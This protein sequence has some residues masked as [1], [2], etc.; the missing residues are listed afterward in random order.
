MTF[1]SYILKYIFKYLNVHNL[2]KLYL[3][4][5]IPEIYLYITIPSFCFGVSRKKITTVEYI[6]WWDGYYKVDR[7]TV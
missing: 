3:T 7:T 6:V 2:E 5:K 1:S 4:G